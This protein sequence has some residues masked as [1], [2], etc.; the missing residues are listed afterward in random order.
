MWPLT[1]N[2]N[3]E[4]MTISLDDVA[5]QWGA[6]APAW[7]ARADEVEAPLTGLQAAFLEA[8][9]VRPG[10]WLL[11][12][13]AGPGALGE[14]WSSLVGPSGRVLLSDI[15]PAMVEA[16]SRRNAAYANVGVATLDAGAIDRPDCSHDV[17]VSRMGLMF[18]SDPMQALRECRR[19]LRAGGRF[20]ALTWASASDNP[21]MACVFG[22]A[23]TTGLLQHQTSAASRDV[24]AL[25]DAD[26]LRSLV[27]AAGFQDVT[28]RPVAGEFR[29]QSV[30]AHVDQLCALAP[31]LALALRVAP[32]EDVAAFRRDAAAQLEAFITNSGLVLPALALVVS[33]NRKSRS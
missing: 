24:F 6:V 8:A 32:A 13:A 19:V 3:I 27:A 21:W 20:A 9:D 22:A 15:A 26:S 18:A 28:V 31:P 17:V 7:E 2:R 23:A 1:L 5:G 4:A 16:A 12:L 30:H 25:G 29:P 14:V 10:N 33:A 11:E